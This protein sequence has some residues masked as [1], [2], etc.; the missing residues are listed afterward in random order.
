MPDMDRLKQIQ[1]V[2]NAISSMPPQQPGLPRIPVARPKVAQWAT[3]LV[4]DYGVRVHTELAKKTLVT[5][6]GSP[7]GN[8][9]PQRAVDV[10]DLNGLLDLLRSVPDVP[11]L[12]QLADQI[13]TALGNDMQERALRDHIARQF[14]DLVATAR[15]MAEQTP[16][17]AFEQ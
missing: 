11:G 8:N 7:L 6:P 9:A 1:L 4:D 16:P 10:L 17:E 12:A 2:A 14:P 5:E 3:E 15:Q 13:E